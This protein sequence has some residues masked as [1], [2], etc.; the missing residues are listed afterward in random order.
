MNPYVDQ[1]KLY[2]IIGKEKNAGLAKMG[3]LIDKLPK[4]VLDGVVKVGSP[5]KTIMQKAIDV[6]AV[7]TVK[8]LIEKGASIGPG[9]RKFVVKGELHGTSYLELAAAGSLAIVKVLLEKGADPN[10]GY[11]TPLR[12]AVNYVKEGL[13]IAT[14]LLD[15]GAD[16]E[17]RSGALDET[18]LMDAVKN[19]NKK[20][21]DLL[22]SK[23]ANINVVD[24]KGQNLLFRICHISKTDIVYF[25]KFLID[26]GLDINS[27]D[28]NGYTPFLYYLRFCDPNLLSLEAIKYMKLY[29]ADFKVKTTE[30][31]LTAIHMVAEQ[32]RW[33]FLDN[34]VVQMTLILRYLLDN[35]LDIDAETNTGQTALFSNMNISTTTYGVKILVEFGANV[36]KPVLFSDVGRSFT[37]LLWS[38]A[39]ENY[40]LVEYFL[41]LPQTDVNWINNEG[42]AAIHYAVSSKKG[43]RLLRLLLTRADIKVDL[44]SGRALV[45]KTS[46]TALFLAAKNSVAFAK[47]LVEHGAD[48]NF[49]ISNGQTPAYVA[50]SLGKSDTLEYFLTHPKYNG[51]ITYNGDTLFALAQDGKF[52]GEINALIIRLSGTLKLWEG[53]TRADLAEFDSIFD[54]RA[55]EFSSCPVCLKYVEREDGCVYIRG[56]KCNSE[57]GGFFHRKLY[58]KFKSTEGTICWCTL[59]GRIC[60]GHRHYELSPARISSM[61]TLLPSGDPFTKDCSLPGAGGGGGL[62]EKL[63]RYRRLREF[64]R[65]LQEEVGKKTEKEALE[66]LVEESWNAPLVRKGILKKIWEKKEWNI[67]ATDFPLPVIIEEAPIDYSKF[68]DIVKPEGDR[69]SLA[70]TVLNGTCSVS[71][72]E[73]QVIQFHH[74]Q[75]NNSGVIFGHENN[76]INPEYLEHFIMGQNPKF[77]TDESFGKC[78]AYPGTCDGLLYPEE[79]KEFVAPE[80]YDEYRKKFNW[81]FRVQVKGGTRRKFKVK[82]GTRKNIIVPA[83]NA[84]CYIGKNK[85]RQG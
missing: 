37:P 85:T 29:G 14:V 30:K 35:G 81:K 75:A 3:E 64:A 9:T 59:C 71:M 65:E 31:G 34:V 63:A 58:N 84:Q 39:K 67:P 83:R 78:W 38:V 44:L 1:K 54:E 70:P 42:F 41:S 40:N 23:G 18:P 48:L 2:D 61:P 73:G 52:N 13:Q 76:Y 77:K 28:N 20:M 4:N 33:G 27:T 47:I 72:E 50:A 16:I 80:V 7:A 74:R 45:G 11:L 49:V 43:D 19:G 57:P 62:Q 55:S 12:R 46:K 32:L 79:I 5:N 36:N 53:W 8:L 69:V 26:K 21:V 15:S 25:L 17:K 10:A 51:E 6:K 60:L 68:P 82:G 56:H 24:N 22:I 66:E